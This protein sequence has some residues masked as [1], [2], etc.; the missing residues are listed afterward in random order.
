LK[1]GRM[2][3]FVGAHAFGGH[4]VDRR[5]ALRRSVGFAVEDRDD[6]G[7]KTHDIK[8]NFHLHLTAS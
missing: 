8:V 4:M 3:P 2:L 1:F 6:I 5:V 7:C